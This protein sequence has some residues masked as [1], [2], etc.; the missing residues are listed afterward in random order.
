MATGLDG[1]ILAVS[2]F[3]LFNRIIDYPAKLELRTLSRHLEHVVTI[4]GIDAVA[5]EMDVLLKFFDSGMK[6][7]DFN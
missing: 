2:I 6:I 7:Q 5:N 4:Y 1:V 3:M